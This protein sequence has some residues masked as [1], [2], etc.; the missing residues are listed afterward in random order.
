LKPCAS[1]LLVIRLS[2]VGDILLAS[3]LAERLRALRPEANVTWLVDE[4]FQPLLAHHPA[5]DR[6]VGYD[7]LGRHRGPAGLRALCAELGP[8]EALYD[9]QHKLR[10]SLVSAALRPAARHVLVKRR[11]LDVVRA[12]LGRDTILRGPHQIERNLSLL[13]GEPAGESPLPRAV[14]DPAALPEARAWR[15]G[16]AGERPAVGLVVGVR[17][18]TKRWPREHWSL[19]AARCLEEGLAVALLGGP[20]DAGDL[21]AL[22]AGLAGERLGVFHAVGLGALMARLACLDALVCPDSGPAHLGAA[23]GRPVLALFGPTSPER[24]APRGPSVAVARLPL[25]CSPCSNHGSGACPLGT[26]ECMRA[27]GVEAVHAE[28]VGLLT[29]EGLAP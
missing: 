6:V 26:H 27:L 25:A 16:F 1:Q 19:L 10:S 7:Y 22:R 18:A 23:L 28:L 4:G 17:H 21:E 9:L 15:R 3:P 13:P 20:E 2:S 5:V 24:W 12:L 11:G 29:H 8:V 14:A